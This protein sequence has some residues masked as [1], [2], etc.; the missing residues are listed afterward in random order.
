MRLP[1]YQ[2][3]AVQRLTP[4]RDPAAEVAAGGR[5][6]TG[7]VQLVQLGADWVDAEVKMETSRAQVQA[8]TAGNAYLSDLLNNP[9][10][11]RDEVVRS[12][13]AVPKDLEGREEIPTYRVMAELYESR[14]REIAEQFSTTLEYE[15]SQ[16][17]FATT[18]GEY[19]NKNALK[20]EK[21]HYDWRYS[22][23][24][25]VGEASLDA[26]L[27]T[28][29][30]ETRADVITQ[31][32]TIISDMVT[33][34]ALAFDDGLLKAQTWAG[35]VDFAVGMNTVFSKD[36]DA[37]EVEM[38]RVAERKTAMTPKQQGQ[39]MRAADTALT[40]IERQEEDA[41]EELQDLNAAERTLQVIE[42]GGAYSDDD[43]MDAARRGQIKAQDA[44]TLLKYNRTIRESEEAEGRRIYTDQTLLGEI[45]NAISEFEFGFSGV[46]AD[47]RK[48][49]IYT[50]ML[51]AMGRNQFNEKTGEQKLSAGDF[52]SRL[53]KLDQAYQAVTRSSQYKEVSNSIKRL[54]AGIE[55]PFAAAS[56]D[57][58]TKARLDAALS[59]LNRH[60]REAPDPDPIEWW[61]GAQDFYVQEENRQ[62][63]TELQSQIA[64]QAFVLENGQKAAFSQGEIEPGQGRVDIARSQENLQNALENGFIGNNEF[65][66]GMR[67]L[68]IINQKQSEI[69]VPIR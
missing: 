7:I 3:G 43:I 32:Q 19:V 30:P 53:V 54:V 55:G 18:F 62:V 68:Q 29:S 13:V 22:H 50:Q 58:G 4:E 27:E 61:R 34:G 57:E 60:M 66:A 41:K 51:N 6:T 9:F 38:D 14:M 59:G 10:I 33:E 2:P 47:L 46:P 11:S 25:G 36:P 31:G 24:R 8:E 23:L 67:V 56:L 15:K 45:D 28:A 48:N 20:V 5:T 42:A 16:K 69:E 35:D 40:R 49:E 37:I 52:N 63:L 64:S 65:D 17:T 39:F 21:Q 44:E 12:G 1:T 26:M